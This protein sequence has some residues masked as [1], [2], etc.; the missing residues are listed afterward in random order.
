MGTINQYLNTPIHDD[1]IK[2]KHFP[3]YWPFVRGIHQSPVNS[4]HKGQWRGA[5]VF[6]WIY[7]WM[8]DW[9]NNWKAGDLRRHRV[10]YDVTAMTQ[11]RTVPYFFAGKNCILG[12]F[13]NKSF[14]C[15]HYSFKRSNS[16][17]SHH[18]KCYFQYYHYDHHVTIIVITIII[19]VIIIIIDIILDVVL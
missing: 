2:W 10:N 17:Y 7:A 4:P 14:K 16:Y 15:K 19:V 12:L 9:V 13:L 11:A 3:F 18:F 5:L 1:V 8:N 6:S